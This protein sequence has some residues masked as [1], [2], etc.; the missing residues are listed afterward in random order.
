MPAKPIVWEERK[1]SRFFGPLAARRSQLDHALL[2]VIELKNDNRSSF[3]KLPK[4]GFGV[5]SEVCNR[6]HL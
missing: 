2:Y 4:L 6:A 5:D 3:V 1:R